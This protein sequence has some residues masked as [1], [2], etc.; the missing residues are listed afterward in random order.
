[1]KL[2][3]KN[4]IAYTILMACYPQA[5]GQTARI[6]TTS[7]V[8]GTTNPTVAEIFTVQTI[9][10]VA[11]A[12]SG[13]YFDIWSAGDLVQY[14][15]WFNVDSVG[16]APSSTGVTLA[17]VV[18]ATGATANQAAAAIKLV[19]DALSDFVAT[20]V[21]D[22]VTVTNAAKGAATNVA[23]G[24][25]GYT[26]GVSTQGVSSSTAIA[27]TDIL[28]DV[29]Y[30]KICADAVQSSTWL[31][32]GEAVDTETDGVRLGKGKC[33]ECLDCRGSVLSSLKVSGQ[34][35]SAAY[36]VIQYKK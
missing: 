8:H 4:M 15:V 5:Y 33:F 7:S 11:G 1:M 35:A 12:S 25:S 24:T 22:T 18:F 30:W 23:A 19:V 31:A 16:T 29:Q 34:A 36:S 17:P 21:T 28:G 6:A 20:V 27:S 2:K 9:A 10:D 3:F 32:V 26:V 13:K 14:R